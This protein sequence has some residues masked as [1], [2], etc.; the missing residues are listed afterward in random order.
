M[1]SELLLAISA[2]IVSVGLFILC[3]GVGV[4][5]FTRSGKTGV[6]IARLDDERRSAVGS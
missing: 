2:L 6:E 1:S 5:F 4:Y 3:A